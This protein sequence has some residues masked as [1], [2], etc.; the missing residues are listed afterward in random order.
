MVY[1]SGWDG[2]RDI[3]R[4]RV[5]EA[6]EGGG[7]VCY[8][9]CMADFVPSEWLAYTM[10]HDKFVLVQP[11]SLWE[12][13][14]VFYAMVRA[15]VDLVVLSG[16]RLCPWD[17]EG[18][19]K[20]SPDPKFA[21]EVWRAYLDTVRRNHDGDTTVL[22]V[23]PFSIK[24]STVDAYRGVPGWSEMADVETMEKPETGPY[25]W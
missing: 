11:N 16:P 8:V 18:D 14:Q 4:R 25:S 23:N 20:M 2:I 19:L 15:G 13:V 1:P 12:A 3:V 17:P 22:A 5:D 21:H 7:T 6:V 9:D 10:D 24:E